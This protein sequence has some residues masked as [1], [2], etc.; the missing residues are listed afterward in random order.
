M[1]LRFWRMNLESW[2]KKRDRLFINVAENI[3]RD[4]LKNYSLFDIM[5]PIMIGPSSSHTAGACR[6]ARVA[7]KILGKDFIKVEFYLHGSF[8][9]TYLGHGT[10]KALVAGALGLDIDD[11]DLK[12]SFK[13][14]RERGIDFEFIKTD[15]GEDVHPNSVKIIFYYPNGRE[16][17]AI[18]C[19]IGGGNI[20]MTNIDGI[21]FEYTNEFPTILLKYREQTGVIAFVSSILSEHGYNIERMTTSKEQ[22]M[23]TLIVELTEE[24]DEE[25]K[26]SILESD[27]FEVAKYLGRAY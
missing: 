11:S 23:V 1:P 6:I 17:M 13:I 3:R 18:G 8:A 9:E 14:A 21:E 15:L 22:D 2:L 24:L 19:S 27:K 5:G 25:N 12:N 20:I 10:D 16:A 26:K 4:R 7:R